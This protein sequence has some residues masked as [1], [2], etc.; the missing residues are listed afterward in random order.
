MHSLAAALFLPMDKI[1]WFGDMGYRHN[2]WTHCPTDDLSYENGRCLCPR[3]DNFD[4][5]VPCTPT[6]IMSE[7]LGL[8]LSSPVGK[9]GREVKFEKYKKKGHFVASR[10]YILVYCLKDPG[11]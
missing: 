6:P 4:N 11:H 8:V 7:D 3:A 9:G 5:D 10:V 1:H 2:P